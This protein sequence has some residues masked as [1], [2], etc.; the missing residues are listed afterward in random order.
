[1]SLLRLFSLILILWRNDAFS[2]GNRNIDEDILSDR[3][4]R[5]T[6]KPSINTLLF[7]L[8]NNTICRRTKHGT[9]NCVEIPNKIFFC[10]DKNLSILDCY[11]LNYNKGNDE[12]EFGA[13]FYNCHRVQSKGFLDDPY[14]TVQT[15]NSPCQSYFNRSG[16][17]CGSCQPDYFPLVYSYELACTKCPNYSLNVWIYLLYVYGPL[18]LF[19]VL[20]LLLKVNATASHL[21]GFIIACQGVSLPVLAR[22]LYVVHYYKKP[23]YTNM[24][25][26]VLTAYSIWNLDIF[27]PLNQSLC[28]SL[29]TL[30][31]YT[32]D[33]AI[34]AY[35]LLFVT[36][37]YG[38][39]NVCSTRSSRVYQALVRP[40][41]YL[42]KSLKVN[43]SLIDAFGT[44]FVLSHVKFM[45]TCLD[46]L[47]W[48]DVYM[49]PASGNITVSRRWYY[50]ANVVYFGR[51]HKPVAVVS[52]LVLLFSF[53]L[54][55]ILLITYPLGLFQRCLNRMP[56]FRWYALHTFMDLFHACY[57]DGTKPGQ[58]DCRWFVGVIIITRFLMCVVGLLNLNAVFFSYAAM[59]LVSVLLILLHIDPYKDSMKKHHYGNFMFFILLAMFY[60]SLSNIIEADRQRHQEVTV[61]FSYA[62]ALIVSVIP[63]LY[64]CYLIARWIIFTVLCR[65]LLWLLGIFGRRIVALQ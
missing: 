23:S 53:V 54:P 50:D 36:A 43:T 34:G 60:T 52:I 49:I 19:C 42:L 7:C 64:F 22:L 31:T 55:T 58:R 57:K 16:S 59:L 24:L 20:I 4:M 45:N 6:T 27:R 21:E 61:H 17:L 65:G 26:F 62:V 5:V 25:K 35:P 33:L 41:Q 1:M 56:F 3:S 12:V 14:K 47:V 46:L 40:F 29:D 9:S 15:P 38:I 18:T 8:D 63:L 11:C 37:V 13:C 32:L 28:L 10:Q 39:S 44:I 51:E 30:G 2:N 48:S